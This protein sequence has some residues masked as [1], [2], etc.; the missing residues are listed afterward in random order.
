MWWMVAAALAGAPEGV[1]VE[2]VDQWEERGATLQDGPAGCFEVVGR[3]TWDWTLGRFGGSRGNAAFVARYEDGVWLDLMVKSLGED[4]WEHRD[5][6]VRVHPHGEL[7]FVP[8]VGRLA[9]HYGDED[10]DGIADNLAQGLIEE[11]GHG[12]SYAYAEWDD[13]KTEVRLQKVVPFGE[14]NNAAEATQITHFPNGDPL[15][16]QIDTTVDQPF[17][18]PDF[19]LARVKHA[20][21]HIRG[22]VVDDVVYPAVEAFELSASAVGVRIEGAQTIRYLT[23]RR[24]GAEIDDEIRSLGDSLTE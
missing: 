7:R 12:V 17:S 6:P 21:A 14:G 4:V 11:L 2:A 13:A 3:A 5:V 22:Q 15:P 8:L 16:S 18:L 24:C 19:R 20:E 1:N 23:W 10:D 9:T